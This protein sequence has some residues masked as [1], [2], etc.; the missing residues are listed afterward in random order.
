[1]KVSPFFFLIGYI[2][3]AYEKSLKQGRSLELK[4]ALI[5]TGITPP[6]K[7]SKPRGLAATVGYKFIQQRESP[8]KNRYQH[9]LRGWYFRPD[10]TISVYQ[11]SYSHD[12][13]EPTNIIPVVKTERVTLSYACLVPTVGFQRVRRNGLVTDFFVGAGAGV[14]SPINGD[15]VFPTTEYSN[16]MPLNQKATQKIGFSYAFKTGLLIG[17][18]F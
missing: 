1:L 11:K 17:G 5:G 4:L 18:L 8:K 14:A 2:P 13:Y 16:Y 3:F 15:K 6:D 9:V 7:E 10:F 12:I